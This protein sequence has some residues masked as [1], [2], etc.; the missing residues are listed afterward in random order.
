MFDLVNNVP[1]RTRT[2]LTQ[3]NVVSSP[4]AASVHRSTSSPERESLTRDTRGMSLLA[5][6]AQPHE[7]VLVRELT[8]AGERAHFFARVRRGEFV[9]IVRGAY[10]SAE[11]WSALD[12][13]ERYRGTIEA[14]AALSDERLV[15]SHESAAS[16]WRLP[17]LDGW[18]KQI[19]IVSARE[20]G[21]RSSTV[22]ARHPVG[23]PE[24]T[25]VIA[26]YDVT[27]LARTVVDLAAKRTLE[28]ATVFADA[29][30]RLAHHPLE[31][32]DK[33]RL[34]KE[35]ESVPLRHGSAR[36]RATID[37]ADGAAD[38]PGE[39]I[40][41]VSMFRAGIAAPQL[42]VEMFGAS[43]SRYVVDFW[44]PQFN[45][46]GEFDGQA[47]YTDPQFLRGRTPEHALRDE[48]FREDDLRATGKGMSRWGWS[49]ARSPAA[50]RSHLRAAGIR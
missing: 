6:V 35:L 12:R 31:L 19:H 38:R 48:K 7:I 30:L 17:S 43:G 10:I 40:S 22:F 47:K 8:I 4:Q 45:L 49:V 9:R 18:P 28:V 24:E 3:S 25:V 39:S 26:G 20:S 44:W 16:L 46:I 2:W 36:A 15:F 33:D 41:R 21:T 50:L 23:I 14:A 13:D 29:A 42:Q 11:T 32:L 5:T 37:F 34:L 1:P 27:T